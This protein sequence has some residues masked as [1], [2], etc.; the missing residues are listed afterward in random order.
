MRLIC[1]K[2]PDILKK[3]ATKNEEHEELK[4][5]INIR[6]PLETAFKI[7]I[8]GEQ[9]GLKRTPFAID[10]LVSAVEDAWQTSKQPTLAESGDLRR[11]YEAFTKT[12]IKATKKAKKTQKKTRVADTNVN[13]N[14]TADIVDI[15]DI[16]E[17]D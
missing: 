15:V 14:D 8:L 10:L 9:Y 6:I 3:L 13:N 7:K 16:T 2:L 11:K 1:Q 4:S 17:T 12:A 5:A